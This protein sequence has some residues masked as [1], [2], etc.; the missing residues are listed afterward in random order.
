MKSDKFAYYNYFF[1]GSPGY[2]RLLTLITETGVLNCYQV[3]DNYQQKNRMEGKNPMEIKGL[4]VKWQRALV[5]PFRKL[6]LHWKPP[7]AT[8]SDGIYSKKNNK[9]CER[10]IHRKEEII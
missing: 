8:G 5:T 7:I 2:T 1:I 6:L 10:Y 9:T 4:V 3:Y